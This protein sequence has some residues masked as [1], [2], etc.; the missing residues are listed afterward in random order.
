VYFLFEN[1]PPPAWLFDKDKMID[2]PIVNDAGELIFGI[3]D[4]RPPYQLYK[5]E[6][7]NLMLIVKEGDTLKTILP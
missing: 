1:N 5:N 6:N 2:L 7:S 4:L 3:W